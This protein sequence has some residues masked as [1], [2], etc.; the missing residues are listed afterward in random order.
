M[1]LPLEPSSAER[2]ARD[3]SRGWGRRPGPDALPG[4]AF[5]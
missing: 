1:S 5:L 2:S 3:D 4:R